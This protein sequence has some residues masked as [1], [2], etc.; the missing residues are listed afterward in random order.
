MARPREFDMQTA[1]QGA[2]DIFWRQGYR[3]TNLPDL[4][5][6]MGLTRGSFYK[7]FT[8]KHSVYLA[9][10]DQYDAQVVSS[11]VDLL[12]SCD[13]ARASDCLAALFEGGGDRSRGC[14][15]CNAMVEC[16]PD[17]R[18]VA[19][20][21]NAMATRIK[22]AIQAVLARFGVAQTVRSHADT[23]E[24]ILHLYFGHQAMGK[25]APPA[26]NWRTRLAELLGE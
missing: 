6:A 12:G 18:E 22:S 5:D 13:A 20:R 14:F 2:T 15:I 1:L 9:A 24:L 26:E 7:A 23:A 21:A 8:D 25:S 3:A 17:D 16:A 10:L 19:G 11:T 4:L